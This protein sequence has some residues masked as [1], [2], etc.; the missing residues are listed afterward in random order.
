VKITNILIKFL[1]KDTTKQSSKDHRETTKK[2]QEVNKKVNT[3]EN[4]LDRAE[5]DAKV[6][7]EQ[8]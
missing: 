4:L 1:S 2:M 7:S 3:L 8:V 5:R 6:K